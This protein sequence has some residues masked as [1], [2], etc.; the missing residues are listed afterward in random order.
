MSVGERYELKPGLE[1]HARM[2]DHRI[3]RERAQVIHKENHSKRK[4]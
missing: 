2:E 4:I 1:K 3:E